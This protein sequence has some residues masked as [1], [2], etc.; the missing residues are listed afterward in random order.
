MFYWYRVTFINGSVMDVAVPADGHSSLWDF[1]DESTVESFEYLGYY[2]SPPEAN[3]WI[4]VDKASVTAIK[5]AQAEAN[6]WILVDKASVTAIKGAPAE[7]NNW[8]L[9]DKLAVTAI[10]GAQVEANNWI[11]VDKF[12]KSMAK[13]GGGGGEEGT[14]PWVW[15]LAAGAAGLALAKI[16]KQKR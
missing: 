14:S 10:K 7:A 16:S 13:R 3:N 1:V 4:L 15:A 8:I 11:L 9:V 2:E 5:G 6:N 12:T